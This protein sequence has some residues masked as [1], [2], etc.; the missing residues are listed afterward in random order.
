[1][2]AAFGAVLQRKVK[3]IN[4]HC[5]DLAETCKRRREK[6]KNFIIRL[7][8]VFFFLIDLDV[9]GQDKINNFDIFLILEL[10]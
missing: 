4:S 2:K 7:S 9:D 10:K 5:V 1:M 6:L 8:S 3:N